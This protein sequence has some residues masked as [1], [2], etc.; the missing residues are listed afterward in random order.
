MQNID[1]KSFTEKLF[2]RESPWTP[3]LRG[4][5]TFLT[6]KKLPTPKRGFSLLET[7]LQV[8]LKP[9]PFPARLRGHIAQRF[10]ICLRTPFFPRIIFF[11]YVP[12]DRLSERVLTQKKK[13]RSL[14]LSKGRGCKKTSP[15][16]AQRTGFGIAKKLPLPELVEGACWQR[17]IATTG[18][19]DGLRRN[20]KPTLPEPAEGA[21]E[22]C[23]AV[24]HGAVL[25][26]HFLANQYKGMGGFFQNNRTP[27]C[28]PFSWRASD[29]ERE[30]R[31]KGR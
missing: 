3:N 13:R 9:L 20:K 8:P 30:R 19:A 11:R 15:R 22:C 28:S 21:R 1:T 23:I 2:S 31:A 14:C 5:T 17:D 27:P 12:F 10:A 7:S 26:H 4:G 18:S 24:G 16:L 29:N 6:L 25:A